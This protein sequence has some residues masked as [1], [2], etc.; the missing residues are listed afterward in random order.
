MKTRIQAATASTS[1]ED[2]LSILSV[3]DSIL[4]EEGFKG[5]YRGFLATML[6]TFSMREYIMHSN[7]ICS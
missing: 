7:S 4:R 2:K 3:L 5:Y 6:N 1:D